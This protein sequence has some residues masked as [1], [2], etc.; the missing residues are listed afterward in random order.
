MILNPY[1][2]VIDAYTALAGQKPS[3]AV[4]A[5]H[6]AYINATSQAAYITALEASFSGA[7]NASM[8]TTILTNLGLTSAF[9]NAQAE[10]YLAANAGARVKAVLD[11]ATG[12]KNY[13][14]TEA[15][16]LTAKTA[17]VATVANAYSYA[18]D[19]ANTTSVAASAAAVVPTGGTFVLTTNADVLNTTTTT[20][21]NKTTAGDDLIYATTN[22]TLTSADIIDGGAGTDVIL[23]GATAAG[24]TLAPVLT[25]VETV[26]ITHTAADTAALTFDA[27]NATG[28]TTVNL[29]NAGAISMLGSDEAITLTALAKGTTVGIIGGIASTAGTGSEIVTVFTGAVAADTQ[30]VAISTLGKTAVLTMS[31]AET[32]NITATG[33]GTTGANTIGSLAATAVKT[34]NLKGSGD[35]TISASDMA[36]TTV[37]NA[38]DA[39]G[40]I[41]FAAEAGTTS[42]TFTG[43][44]GATSVSGTSTGVVKVTTAGADDTVDLSGGNSTATVDTGAGADRV[45]VGAQANVTAADT[46]AGG[47]DSDTV[48]ITDATINLATKTALALGVS[49]FEKLET[50]AAGA[51]TIDYNALSAYDS[52]SLSAA[53][54]ASTATTSTVGS[55]SVTATMENGD[56]L[57]ITAARV[58]QVGGV[59]SAGGE[60][61]A[62]GGNGITINSKLDNGGNIA[63]LTLVGNAD[64]SAGAGGDAVGTFS[65][66]V[67]GDAIDASTVETL[68][69]TVAGTQALIA[70]VDTVTLTAAAGGGSGGANGTAGAAGET[71]KV[72]TNATIKLTST[73]EGATAAIHNH[74]NLGT[75]KGTNVTLNGADFLGNITATA[76]DGNVTL[77]GGAGID[78]LVGGAG[79]DTISGGAGNDVITGAAGADVLAGGTGR[80]SFTIGTAGHSGDTA[81]DTI[82]D[83]GKVTVAMTAAQVTAMNSVAAF[84]AAAT[85]L[86]G[87]D[88]D[89]IDFATTAALAAAAAG[90]DV[91]AAVTGAGDV[92]TA[93]ISA[94]GVITLAGADAANADTLAGWIAVA[95]IM[96]ADN[97]VAVFEFGGNTYAYQDATTSDVVQLTG[98]TGVT[99]IVLAG[100]AV[101]AAAGDIVVI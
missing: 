78:N 21:A 51:T 70:N 37:V 68:N 71:L 1:A 41:T 83:F 19:P 40:V 95:A 27:T 42:F 65:G 49:G 97:D 87:A 93:S 2:V 3:A 26:T 92:V 28:L 52:V 35:L 81:G 15:A 66:G 101:A 88:S 55:D 9:T 29:K 77:T 79:V 24:Q 60:D 23:A 89:I 16:I 57:V 64:I 10:A 82:S 48:V 34:L 7:T 99:G 45:L 33:T 91:A 63:N 5:E 96:L 67:G 13:S 14:G 73:L 17:Y 8:A 22:A 46:I 32:V 85:G 53:M 12:L 39:A 4:Y 44:A 59:G 61:G 76:A 98:V 31:T 43:G 54:A 30:D 11:L 74:I 80:D 36:A 69:I 86:S 47:A 75:I 62:A 84:Q 50:T 58:G 100:G 94:K 72:G 56:T 90:T 18:I 25:G 6:K 38:A 20:A